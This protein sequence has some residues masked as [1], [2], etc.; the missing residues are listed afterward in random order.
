M[1]ITR[2]RM[3]VDILII[4]AGPAG[5]SAAIRLAQRTPN[6]LN[7]VVL[8]KGAYVGAHILSGAVL[9]PCAL[10]ALLPD[11]SKREPPDHVPVSNDQFDYLTKNHH[12]RLP[13]PK[14]MQN[15]QNFI[16]SLSQWCQWL[17]QQA[18]ALGVQIF[19]SFAGQELLFD[20]SDRLIGIQTGDMGLDKNNQPGPRFQP[21]VLLYAKQ[22]LVAEG[23]RGYLSEQVIKKYQLRAHCDPQSYALG[24]KELWRVPSTQHQLGRVLHTVGWPLDNKTYGGSFLYHFSDSRVALGFVVGLD[25]QN[26]YLDPFQILQQWKTHPSIQ[27]ILENGECIQYGARALNEGG[28]Q[29]IPKLSFPGGLLLGDAAGFLN[30]GKIK[31]T[32]NAMW[33]GILAADCLLAKTDLSPGDELVEFTDQVKQSCIR[34]DLYPVRNMRPGFHRGLHV[35][36][37]AA[38]IDQYIFRG[39][40]PWTWHYQPDHLQLKAARYYQP[41][42]YPATKLDRLSALSL[43]GTQHREDQASHLVLHDPKRAIVP[44]WSEYASPEQRYCPA[45]VYEIVQSNSSDGESAVRLQINSSN[46]LH[47]KTCDIKDP[48]QNI[49]WVPPEGGGGPRYRDM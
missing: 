46:C 48:T 42:D 2:E 3:D 13:T 26:P 6:P 45:A 44:N 1:D 28:W 36:L 12:Y 17:A 14:L 15:D 38:A 34:E 22:I 33:S 41:I 35:G 43:S 18:E 4:G 5:L 40:A 27:P 30:V 25:Y 29:A 16:I 9:Q 39:H 49:Q 10:Q 20:G 31:G 24:I 8:E 23:C 19:T 37:A 47:C 21:G 11:W 32:H 7:I